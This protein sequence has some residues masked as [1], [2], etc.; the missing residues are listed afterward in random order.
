M[1]QITYCDMCREILKPSDKKFLFGYYP[2]TEED[3]ETNK[4]RF[5]EI[6]KAL[7]QGKLNKETSIKIIEICTGCAGVFAHFV[8]LRK[9]ELIKSRREVRRMLSRKICADKKKEIKKA[10]GEK[11]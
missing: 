8:N 5:E 3:E 1:A 6:I 7:Y 2:C 4:Q 10:K 11:K 9:K